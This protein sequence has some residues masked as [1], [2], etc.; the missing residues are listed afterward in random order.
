MECHAGADGEDVL[1][2]VLR[3]LPGL[4]Q[5]RLDLDRARL[6]ARQPLGDVVDQ[7]QD[8]AV[9]VRAGDRRVELHGRLRNG[10]DERLATVLKGDLGAAS[11]S[12]V[13]APASALATG[14]AR[15][16]CAARLT[17]ERR[18]RR[19]ACKSS[20]SPERVRSS[21]VFIRSSPFPI[22]TGCRATTAAHE[23]FVFYGAHSRSF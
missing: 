15:P 5:R 21:R 16:I 4:R 3:D 23:L 14:I 2:T 19:A 18:L 1:Q 6:E 12:R 17:N 11:P 20:T 10:D 9:A 7:R 8:V 13:A 22:R